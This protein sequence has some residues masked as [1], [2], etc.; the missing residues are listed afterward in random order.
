[1][2]VDINFTFLKIAKQIERETKKALKEEQ[3][4]TI[5]DLKRA[6]SKWKTPAEF[7]VEKEDEG[8]TIVT[9]DD[10]YI[11]VDEG[12]APHTIV[13]K[14]NKFLKFRPGDRVRNEIA[15]RQ[16]TQTSKDVAVYTKTV[17]HPGIKPR[18]FTET[19]MRKRE[20]KFT[21]AIE[22]AVEKAIG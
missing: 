7:T 16:S 9:E 2:A 22:D 20:K 13:P 5:K 4:E 19:V 17:H 8:A 6:T 21:S 12:T 15:R 3:R 11:W 1:M 10:R 18:N 14:K